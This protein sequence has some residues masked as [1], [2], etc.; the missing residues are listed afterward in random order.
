MESCPCS[1]L[2]GRL[3]RLPLAVIGMVQSVVNAV[4]CAVNFVV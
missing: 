2:P 1:L 3:D 4:Y